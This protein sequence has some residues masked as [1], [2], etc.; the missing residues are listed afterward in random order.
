MP[1]DTV[2]RSTIDMAKANPDILERALKQMGF[3]VTKTQTGLQFSK[4]GVSGTFAKDKLNI[5]A[6]QGHELETNEVKRAYSV[7][8][9]KTATSR[10]G[11][12]MKQQKDQPNKF[13][14]Q[15]R[16]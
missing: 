4:F 5:T 11:W 9:V 8:L 7:E 10:F 14:V 3:N 16:Y 15:R 12:T 2:S 1:C 6:R 13:T